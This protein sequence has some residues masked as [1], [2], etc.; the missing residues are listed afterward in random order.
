MSCLISEHCN[1]LLI[2]FESLFR[3]LIY[4]SNFINHNRS[5]CTAIIA[6]CRII[7]NFIN[8]LRICYGIIYTRTRQNQKSRGRIPM[9]PTTMGGRGVGRL[10]V[11]FKD[12]ECAQKRSKEA[13]SHKK[14][15]R[16]DLSRRQPSTQVYNLN[17]GWLA[18]MRA[19]APANVTHCSALEHFATHRQ[20]QIL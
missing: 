13:E 18:G 4:Y 19:A 10:A 2:S 7:Y 20:V 1:F 9:I 11:T 15:S 5:S 17:Q 14:R 8:S 16:E 6:Q 3:I 12:T